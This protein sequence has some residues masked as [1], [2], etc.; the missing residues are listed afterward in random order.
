MRFGRRFIE[1][2][3]PFIV[4][5]AVV[6]FFK[7]KYPFWLI[8]FGLGGILGT[9]ILEA[10][11]IIYCIFLEP[12]QP[13]SKDVSD[14]LANKNLRGALSEIKARK[15]EIRTKIFHTYLFQ[16]IFAVLTFYVLTST[17][18]ALAS[19]ICLFAFLH[20]M[21]DQIYELSH[22]QGFSYGWAGF[23]GVTISENLQKYWVTGGVLIFLYFIFLLIR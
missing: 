3:V 13:V 18:S 6:G 12:E 10:E 23:L 19:G 2:F 17:A 9:F 20:L 15:A 22:H 11:S 4:I 14:L 1:N 5:M 21:K 7:V 8:L 16:V